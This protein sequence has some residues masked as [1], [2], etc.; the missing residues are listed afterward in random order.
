[1]TASELF[2]TGKLGEAVAAQT[3]EVKSRPA[4]HARRLFLF[5]LLAF[6]GD[7]ER[8]RK[9]IDLLQYN[10][11]ELDAATANYR[12]LLDAEGKRRRFA[13]EGLEPGFFTEPPEHVRLRVRAAVAARSDPAEAV[14]LL[15]R[16]EELAP[17]LTGK[18]NGKSFTALRDADDVLGPVLEVLAQGGYYWVPLEQVEAVAASP[19]KFPRDLLWLPAQLVMSDGAAGNVFLPALY[20]GSH[21]HAD[22][23]VKLGR[24]TDWSGPEGGPVRGAGLRTFLVNDDA[25][26]LLE[27]QQLEIEGRQNESASEPGSPHAAPPAT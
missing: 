8:A 15:G 2:R 14:R 7:L 18:L 23:E 4:D 12:K 3:Q 27:W 20:V 21:E 19:P 6:A 16:A 22:E 1:M 17:P 9:Q 5:E 25:A 26:T 24:K 13:A 11:P 10:D